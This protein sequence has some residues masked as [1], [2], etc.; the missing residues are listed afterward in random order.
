MENALPPKIIMTQM[1]FGY[2]VSSAIYTVAKLNIA[3]LLQKNGPMTTESLAKSTGAH[4]ESLYRLLRTLAS[5]GI[6]SENESGQFSLTPMAD[7]LR[8]DSA[9]S[10]KSMALSTGNSFYRAYGEL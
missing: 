9:D 3:D 5:I 2:V 7:C 4:E 1:I 8:D 10:V 6:F